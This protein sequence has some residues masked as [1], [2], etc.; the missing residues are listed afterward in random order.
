MEE[1][2]CWLKWQLRRGEAIEQKSDR[3]VERGRKKARCKNWVIPFPYLP[4][5]QVR[6]LSSWLGASIVEYEYER[7]HSLFGPFALF[8]ARSSISFRLNLTRRRR[9]SSPRFFPPVALSPALFF[10]FFL[11]FAFGHPT[12]HSDSSWSNWASFLPLHAHTLS[13]SLNYSHAHAQ[14]ITSVRIRRR[15]IS[16][17]EISFLIHTDYLCRRAVVYCSERER[18]RERP[19]CLF[20]IFC[21]CQLWRTLR[22]L[23]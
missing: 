10:L 19:F 8:S 5:L 21:E 22:I 2:E 17:A 7:F 23:S 18:E 9:S 11:L 4:I 6:S 3:L 14:R 12:R 15:D 16:H 1:R 20:R 13:V